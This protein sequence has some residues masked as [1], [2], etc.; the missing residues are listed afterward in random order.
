MKHFYLCISDNDYKMISIKLTSVVYNFVAVSSRINYSHLVEAG[1]VAT[2]GGEKVPGVVSGLRGMVLEERPEDKSAS[3][4]EKDLHE[5]HEHGSLPN[6]LH[7]GQED[8][9]AFK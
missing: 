1:G 2:G 5:L 7:N 6:G 4:F 8:D 3:P 9:K